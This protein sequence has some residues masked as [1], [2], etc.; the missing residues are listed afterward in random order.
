VARGTGGQTV[1][2]VL[3]KE[4]GGC[5]RCGRHKTWL[6]FGWVCTATLKEVCWFGTVHKVDAVRLPPTGTATFRCAWVVRLGWACCTAEGHQGIVVH[7]AW[8]K[9]VLRRFGH[10]PGDGEPTAQVG[11]V[12]TWPKLVGVLCPPFHRI[13]RFLVHGEPFVA[14]QCRETADASHDLRFQCDVDGR[15]D[16]TQQEE[17]TLHASVYYCTR[18]TGGGWCGG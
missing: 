7:V 8:A 15:S 14:T 16:G 3:R 17:D 5:V 18:E 10:G 11:V 9:F 6:S 2:K 13:E 1:A 12:T 4:I